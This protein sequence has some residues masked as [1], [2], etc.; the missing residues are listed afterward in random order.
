MGG[1]SRFLVKEHGL[2][3]DEVVAARA[4]AEPDALTERERALIRFARR[5]A[6]RPRQIDAADIAALRTVGLDDAAIVEALS[7]CM[8]SAWTNT[9]ADT[10]KF[11]L[12][13]EELGMRQNYF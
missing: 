9:L 10:L 7:V 2:S 13:L 6:E 5:V 1:H 4:G 12:D 11:D 3:E 8:M